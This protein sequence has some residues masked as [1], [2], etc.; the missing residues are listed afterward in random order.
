MGTTILE[1]FWRGM[2]HTLRGALDQ[3]LSR[4]SRI[5]PFRNASSADGTRV[6]DVGDIVASTEGELKEVGRGQ[7]VLDV[8]TDAESDLAGCAIDPEIT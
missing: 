8:M 1:R 6:L 5:V 7:R 2:N 4:C 3:P